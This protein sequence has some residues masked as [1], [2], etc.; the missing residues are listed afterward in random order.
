M[1]KTEVPLYGK[2]VEIVQQ[3]DN[4]VLRKEGRGLNDLPSRH[5]LERHGP[6]RL[7][8]E[9]ELQMI[10]RLFAIFGMYSCWLL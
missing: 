4:A 9:H 7:R 2:L 10:K 1:Y 3:V 5:H 6:I 8:T